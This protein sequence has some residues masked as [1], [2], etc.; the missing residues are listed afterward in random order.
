[1]PALEVAVGQVEPLQCLAVGAVERRDVPC[2]L[3]RVD[4]PRLE[5]GDRRE[6]RLPEAGEA[7][8]RPEAVQ[9]RAG[10]GAAENERP[11]RLGDDGRATPLTTREQLEEIVERADRP[12]QQRSRAREQLPLNA[13]DL[14]PVR[15]DEERLAVE[16]LEVSIEEPRDLPRI[17]RAN[18][19]RERH[20]PILPAT[21]E[22]PVPP[23]WPGK[24]PVQ[25][26]D[27]GLR[28]RRA[29]ARPGIVPAQS[30]HRSAAFAPRRASV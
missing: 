12:A 9:A 5:L 18:Q 14:R 2:R 6:Q 28:P 4:Q 21:P 27:F 13:V 22:A 17:R 1:V 16:V 15:D 30:S 29:A 19:Q 11:L 24:R 23:E 25:A 10:E 7:R 20:R 26:A 8:R 3:V